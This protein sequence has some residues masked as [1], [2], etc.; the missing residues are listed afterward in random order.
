MREQAYR[1]IEKED[2]FDD[3]YQEVI[4]QYWETFS[5][6]KK[7]MLQGTYNRLKKKLNLT[8]KW[9]AIALQQ[10]R[11]CDWEQWGFGL[12]T[13]R[14]FQENVEAQCDVKIQKQMAL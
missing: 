1:H 13:L 9:V 7:R 5:P 11:E 10:K 14:G 6:A 12:F 4:R 2:D 3:K 8:P